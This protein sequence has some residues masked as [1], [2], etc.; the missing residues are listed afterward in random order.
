M[1]EK[2]Q[3]I[4]NHEISTIGRFRLDFLGAKTKLTLTNLHSFVPYGGSSKDRVYFTSTSGLVDHFFISKPSMSFKPDESEIDRHN[5]NTLIQHPE[6]KIA[7]MSFEEYDKLVKANLKRSN[8]KFILINVDKVEDNSFD[9]ET[10]LIKARYALVSDEKSMTKYRLIHLCS[11]FGISYRTDITEVSR[12]RKFLVKQLDHFL[13]KGNHIYNPKEAIKVFMESLAD[14]KATEYIY[15][16]NEFKNL[17]IIKDLGGIY[18][19]GERPIG[20][21]INAIMKYYEQNGEIFLEHKKL[22]DENNKGTVLE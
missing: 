12:Y 1:S 9:R 13:S 10:E 17:E 20:S 18:K 11:K 5:V 15:Y 14:I 2:I 21:D 19:V 16:I 8:P 3:L 4:G 22:V 7:S 6:V